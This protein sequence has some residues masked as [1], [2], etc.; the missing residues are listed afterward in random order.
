MRRPEPARA[1]TDEEDGSSSPSALPDD[2]EDLR[3][4][5]LADFDEQA[6]LA[7]LD[8]LNAKGPP[9]PPG[10]TVAPIAEAPRAVTPAALE[11]YAPP[12]SDFYSTAIQ[13]L[14]HILGSST[15]YPWLADGSTPRA[16]DGSA[17]PTWDM[18]SSA[19]P[20]SSSQVDLPQLINTLVERLGGPTPPRRVREQDLTHLLQTLLAQQGPPTMLPPDAPTSAPNVPAAAA[21]PPAPPAAATTRPVPQPLAPPQPLHFADLTFPEEEEDDPDFLPLSH[22]SD[23][24]TAPSASAWSRAMEEMV[25]ARTKKRDASPTKPKRGRP[26][27]FT[28]EEAMARKRGRNRDYMARQ[29]E[30][31]Q[32]DTPSLAPPP[33]QA[34]PS[35]PEDRLVLEA[36]NRFLRTELER[37]REENARLRGREEMRAYAARLGLDHR[38]H[39]A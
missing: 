20:V 4:D 7:Q 25:P 16:D 26:R 8:L 14:T 22:E 15:P 39:E 2:E 34:A 27:Q 21:T 23:E 35:A 19:H 18:A 38:T 37:L 10:D 5:F 30:K 12:S 32:G 13:I 3:S 31:K 1:R 6:F 33:V 11:T 9:A 17:A 29:R 28:A 24:L 36:E